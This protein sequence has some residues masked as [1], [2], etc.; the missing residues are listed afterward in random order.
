MENA[1]YRIDHMTDVLIYADSMADASM[2]NEV[3]VPVPDP[4][5]YVEKDGERHAVVTSFEISRIE[6]VGIKAHPMEEFG[7]D[8]LLAQG[9]PRHEVIMRTLEAAVPQLGVS[10]AVV[11]TTFPIGLADRLR[12]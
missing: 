10:E 12:A 8:E 7:Y 1:P 9:L 3:P 11:P 5:L 6:P 4:F 2:R